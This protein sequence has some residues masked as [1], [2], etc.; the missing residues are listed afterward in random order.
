MNF[1]VNLREE[2]FG[3][4]TFSV[5]LFNLLGFLFCDCDDVFFFFWQDILAGLGHRPCETL[6]RHVSSGH[7]CIFGHKATKFPKF[8][9]AQDWYR[10]VNKN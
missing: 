6:L 5:L 3:V 8:S 1:L 2:S 10:V 4:L 9:D 7:I